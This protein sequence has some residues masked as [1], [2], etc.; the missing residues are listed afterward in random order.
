MS[1]SH[2]KGHFHLSMNLSP[3]HSWTIKMMAITD[4]EDITVSENNTIFYVSSVLPS[5][6]QNFY[7]AI[8]CI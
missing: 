1:L 8:N 7:N 3:K 4:L 6:F 2:E 5:L